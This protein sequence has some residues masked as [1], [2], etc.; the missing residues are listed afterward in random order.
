VSKRISADAYAA[1]VKL[2]ELLWVG[3]GKSC[4][5]VEEVVAGKSIEE[6][7]KMSRTYVPPVG[8]Q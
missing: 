3:Y 1:V 7:R 8:R 5:G 4:G 2:A 6:I